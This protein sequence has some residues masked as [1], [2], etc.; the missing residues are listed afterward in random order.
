MA[1]EKM[2]FPIARYLVIIHFYNVFIDILY[3]K[4]SV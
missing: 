4:F 3:P 2:Q 1:A